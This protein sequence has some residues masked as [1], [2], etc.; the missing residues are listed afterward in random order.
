MKIFL[1]NFQVA[2][3]CLFF[4]AISAYAQEK[5]I[6]GKITSG[7][8]N[9]PLPGVNVIVKGTAIGTIS[10]I[11][12]NFTLSA[13]ETADALVFSYIGFE[14]QEVTINGQSSFSIS[15]K[16]DAQ[17][18]SE[19]VVTALNQ[20]R[21]EK[22]I[23]YAVQEVD[24]KNLR[25]ARETNL[26]S[27]MAGKIAGVQVVSGSGAKFGTPAIRIRGVRGL[28][29]GSPLYVVDGI[30]ISD[31][32]T[33]NMDNVDKI[34][35]LKGPS[36]AALYGSRARDGVVIITS[37]K[38]VAGQLTIDLNSTTTFEKVS[39]L[40]DYQNEYGGGYDQ[41]FG[42]F[43]YVE[44]VHDPALAAIDGAPIPEFY[45][46]E[47]WGPKMD[48]TMVAQWDA[49]TKGTA[50]F[51]KLR[52]WSPQPD[53]VKN[54]F[55]T[56]VAQN[57]GITVRKAGDS[58]NI[59]VA[60]TDIQRSGVIP[61]TDQKRNFLNLNSSVD[62][63]KNL[64][65]NAI[66][67]Y[68]KTKTNGNL[69]E[70]YGSIGSNVN[71]WFQ[72]QLDMD[73]LEKYYQ[74]PDGSYTSWNIN[75][76]SN[77]TPLYWDNPYTYAYANFSEW[78]RTTFYGK[79][80]LQWEPVKGLTLMANAI[81]ENQERAGNSR[82]ATGTLGTDGYSAYSWRK[83]EDN[84]EFIASYSKDFGGL[85]V[86]AIG[87]GN[88]RKNHSTSMS[89]S[90]SGGLSVPHL[91]TVSNSKDRPNAFSSLGEKEVRSLYAQLSLGYKDVI[92]VDASLRGDWDS[93]LPV[94][95]N[96][97]KYPSIS[98]SF[99]F[100]ELLP[101]NDLL[102]FGKLRASYATVGDELGA[103]A[104]MPT[105][106]LGSP[107]GSF[108]TMGTPD[109]QTLPT[110]IA[111]TTSGTEGGIELRFLRDRV[112]FDFAYYYYDNTDEIVNVS[113]PP[114]SGISTVRLNAG[115]STTKGWEFSLGGIP[116]QTADGFV[117]DV[118]FNLASSKNTIEALYPELNLEVISLSNGWGGTGTTGG[119]GGI[120]A[121]AKVGEEWGTIV[122]R[123]FRTND[124]GQRVVD[125]DGYP[126]YDDNEI[127]GTILP[128]FTGGIFNRFSYKNVELAFT[129]DFQ[130]GGK[131]NSITKM[132]N[133]YSG[134]GSETV[135]NNDKGNPMRDPVADGGGLRFEGV[136]ENDGT[137]NTTYLSADG[138]WKSLFGLHEAWVY[139][140]TFVKVREV[141]LGYSLPS[142]LLS[143][144]F[145]KRASIAFVAN[146][147]WL[148]YT[149]ASGI[150][151]SELGGDT[152]DARINGAWVDGGQLPAT[153]SLG[154]DLKI[155][156]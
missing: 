23:G 19:V 57:T 61:G 69:D 89:S 111:A 138:Y 140:A 68:S 60:V 39:V 38:G 55:E 75:S 8:D 112:R 31:A 143:N 35:V 149:A 26:G 103:Y 148:I 118:N 4:S 127:L 100:T 76:T 83:Q 93:A 24:S 107:Y 122:G 33:I 65:L 104:I 155:G 151:P 109:N 6:T 34:S 51:G 74:L 117:W 14:T 10:G 73:L 147:P 134:L 129:I 54:Y 96:L 114:T 21:E 22:S 80:G 128:D 50:G 90:T 49:F 97:T 17:E 88:L 32:S 71:Q 145:I 139:D 62:L 136:Y 37:K 135:G 1:R 131:F 56:G 91:Y 13:P 99:V 72:R 119:W 78:E 146:N 53:N 59:S 70:G 110:L 15:M 64:K 126:L 108:P 40:P 105:Y 153:R 44:G 7:A 30:I 45:A 152:E 2:F 36:A 102:S 125:A 124:A 18:L 130:S 85:S 116:L 79:V 63:V 82:H 48:G 81:R 58:Y 12:G 25:V 43:E 66:A 29:S 5:V 95:S 137:E 87:G 133:A 11:D 9:S 142:S 132:F 3:L 154:V 113:V 86:S 156:F 106:G 84:F 47:S 67:N 52:P 92:F 101:Q 41:S 42:A 16:E 94:N 77:T 28:S 141:R 121:R 150:D 115:K 27:A 123:K 98:T 120:T 20:N 46:D 144:T